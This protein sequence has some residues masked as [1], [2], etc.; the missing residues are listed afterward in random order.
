MFTGV[1]KL[2]TESLSARLAKCGL[3][4]VPGAHVLVQGEGQ[5]ELKGSEETKPSGHEI[6]FFLLR[7]FWSTS[8]WLIYLILAKSEDIF[9]CSILSRKKEK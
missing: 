2:P 5:G 3:R 9:E 6:G 1:A 8:R 7:L 4:G